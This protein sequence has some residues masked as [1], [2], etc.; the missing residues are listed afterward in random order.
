MKVL[1]LIFVLVFAA[2]F[3][4]AQTRSAKRNLSSYENG[5]E[6]KLEFNISETER[7]AAA[8]KVREFLWTHWKNKK[9]G[10]IKLT[11][12]NLVED[13]YQTTFYTEPDS[14]G[15]WVI[16]YDVWGSQKDNPPGKV[17]E[18]TSSGVYDSIDRIEKATR[19]SNIEEENAGKPGPV[20]IPF[21]SV[22]G[23]ETY[24]LRLKANSATQYTY[25]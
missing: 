23:R 5:G 2:Q 12:Y 16:N 8:G 17:R 13:P 6:Y 19:P 21:N 3:S 14:S 22:R 25:L 10:F 18:F 7:A 4:F 9:L 15:R 20:V 11:L 1:A 24:Y